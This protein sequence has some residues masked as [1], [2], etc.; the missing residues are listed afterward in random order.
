MDTN[1]SQ[2]INC[3]IKIT[4]T[5]K[6]RKTR[7]FSMM[8]LATAM[9]AT[10]GCSKPDDNGNEN[11]GNYGGGGTTNTTQLSGV[12]AADPRYDTHYECNYRYPVLEFVNSNTI[13]EYINVHDDYVSPLSTISFPDHSGWYYGSKSTTT[14][15]FIDNKVYLTNGDIY[16]FMDGKLYKDNSSTVLYSWPSGSN[17]S[18][19]SPQDE[20]MTNKLKNT[21]WRFEK[22]VTYYKNTGQTKTDTYPYGTISFRSSFSGSS[23]VFHVLSING[24][25][26]AQ[27]LFKDGEIKI[28]TTDYSQVT[29]LGNICMGGTI[30]KLTSSTLVTI[31][32]FDS[33]TR[34]YYYTSE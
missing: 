13:V 19:L 21:T 10:A 8:L 22:S 15:T 17:S 14:Y 16:T 4:S 28:A 23:T 32:E 27:W 24:N 31:K 20:E 7:L 6:T 29:L 26:F 1:N 5:M 12:W 11:N 9:L 2:I 34:T 3:I 25:P 30:E 33:F 18:N